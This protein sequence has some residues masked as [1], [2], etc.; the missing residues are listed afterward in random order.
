MTENIEQKIN[1]K[2][3]TSPFSFIELGIKD[4]ADD[5][6][7][8]DYSGFEDHI[9]SLNSNINELSDRKNAKILLEQV[10]ILGKILLSNPEKSAIEQAIG[11]FKKSVSNLS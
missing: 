5:V 1:N 11:D 9:R 3:E 8:G 6:E 2:R 10:A 7:N 4:L